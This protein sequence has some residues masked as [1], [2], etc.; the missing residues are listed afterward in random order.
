MKR[1]IVAILALAP[2]ALF[3]QTA[4]PAQPS[5]TQV[6]QTSVSQPASLV[7]AKSSLD[8]ASVAPA[9]VR[10]STGVTAPKILKSV[11]ID[12][13][14]ATLTKIPGKDSVVV[15]A[16]TVDETGKPTNLKVVKSE[17]PFTDAG[18]LEAVSQYR[19]QPGTLD[20]RAMALPVTIE[21]TIK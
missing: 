10:I 11:E 21:Y 13:Q 4:T 17:D 12:R 5:S 14:R 18:V 9:P 2:A 8:R 15:V 16:M 19:F 1:T 7:A 20:G 3:A 6:L